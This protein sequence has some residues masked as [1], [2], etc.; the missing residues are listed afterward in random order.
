[1]ADF[2]RKNKDDYP[3]LPTTSTQGRAP[4]PNKGDSSQFVF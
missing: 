3:L 1:M 2:L 4:F